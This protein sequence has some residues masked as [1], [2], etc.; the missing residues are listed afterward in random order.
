MKKVKLIGIIALL[1]II[2]LGMAGCGSLFGDK[3]DTLTVKNESSVPVEVEMRLGL[4]TQD[5]TFRTAQ[6]TWTGTIAP[7]ATRTLTHLITGQ[8]RS[9][10]S[11]WAL[12][13]TVDGKSRSGSRSGWVRNNEASYTIT[14]TNVDVL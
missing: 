6:K 2:V 14:Q 13:Y 5:G 9:N 7:G 3:G 12:R 8:D 11:C 4:G 10:Y 1:A